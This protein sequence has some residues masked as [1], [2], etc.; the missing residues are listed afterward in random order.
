[1]IGNN[2]IEMCQAEMQHAMETYLNDHVF[3]CRDQC[4]VQSVRALEGVTKT[5]EIHI[6]QRLGEEHT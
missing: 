2:K 3:Q 5:F 4:E 1:M 6:I